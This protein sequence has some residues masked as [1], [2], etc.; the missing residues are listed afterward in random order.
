MKFLIG[1]DQIYFHFNDVYIFKFEKIYFG[2]R[3]PSE[4]YTVYQ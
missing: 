4:D 3:D 1:T 2:G